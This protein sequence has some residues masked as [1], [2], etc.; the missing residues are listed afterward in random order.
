MKKTGG[1]KK[2]ILTYPLLIKASDTADTDGHP[3]IYR[4]FFTNHKT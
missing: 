3:F 2:E 1:G 4:F